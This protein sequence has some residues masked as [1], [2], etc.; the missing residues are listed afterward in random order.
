MLHAQLAHE[1][2]RLLLLGTW[3]QLCSGL[4]R[5]CSSGS[6]AVPMTESFFRVAFGQYL[7]QRL[8]YEDAALPREPKIHFGD[9]CTFSLANAATLFGFELTRA[10]WAEPE[11]NDVPE[12][13][14]SW[15]SSHDRAMRRLFVLHHVTV[16]F[17]HQQPN[18]QLIV[19]VAYCVHAPSGNL[20]GKA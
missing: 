12:V 7:P 18:Q 2:V 6:I 4:N 5:A 16:S 8:Y 13:F 14:F 20:V 17:R 3:H 19:R 15:V 1:G 9:D 10:P 11:D